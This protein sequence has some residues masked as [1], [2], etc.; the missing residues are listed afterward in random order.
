M[1]LLWKLRFILK[2]YW[3]QYLLAFI[4][5]QIVSALNLLP[6]WLIGQV[7]DGIKD[8]SLTNREL[9][10]YVA[11][12]MITGLTVYGFRY[13]WRSRLYG[14]SIELIRKQRSRL[15]AHFTQ[16]SPEFYQ[17]HTTGD[18]MAH[19]TNDLNA[20][21]ESV[22]VGVMT[23]VDSLIAGITVLFA[24][25]FL[26]SGQL[27][28]LAMLPFPVLVWVTKR[29]GVALYSRFGRSQAAFSS[30]NE[31]TRESITGIRAVK[32]HQLTERQTQRFEQ[33][34]ME[35][36]EANT[37][38]ARVDALFGPSISLFFGLSFVLA[39]VGGAWL[40][41]QGQL[42]VGLLTSFT[43]YLSQM[44]GPM[45]QFGWQFNVFQRGSA[46]WGRLEKLLARQPKV[47]NAPDAHQAPNDNSFSINI[48]SFGYGKESV[49]KN[50]TSK[51]PA[52]S[53]IGITGRTGS[54]K[55]TL[56][57]LILREFDLPEGSSIT[58]GD[59]PLQQIT[60][61]SLRK[62]LAWVPQEPMLFSGTIADNIRFPAPDASLEAVEKAAALAAIDEEI[63]GFK[64]GYNTLLGENGINL[65]GGQKQ[66]LALARALLADAEI[67]L[68]DDAFSALDMKTEAR[69]LKNL[70][71]MKG[72]K[73]IILVTQRL[74]EL[75]TAD[76]ILVLD[77]GHIIEQGN[78]EQLLSIGKNKR[79]NDQPEENTTEHWYAKI[80]Q[81]QARTL[82]QPLE[83]TPDVVTKSDVA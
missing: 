32:A 34:S 58:M 1:K 68:L 77:R 35:A 39:L 20:V 15:F 54:G 79:T 45:L 52:G 83:A 17:H 81:Q 16:L 18:L 69:I 73:T 46:S 72:K 6:P 78:H 25:V 60:V 33:L 23:L 50:I 53:F 51:I 59:I 61:E 40:I 30:L 22:G 38:V 3:Q 80:F 56:L 12:I 24:M 57:R 21:E 36:V 26:V 64:D 48:Q 74:P 4:C 55:S 9:T 8:N 62:K 2:D 42:T 71:A 76:H 75:I 82:L 11:G 47:S 19:A 63:M 10:G 29:Y 65:S 70:M 27:T 67:L 43:L 37:S 49:L 31:E 28:L 66:R 41:S 14:A 7:V 44:L 5:L 13:V